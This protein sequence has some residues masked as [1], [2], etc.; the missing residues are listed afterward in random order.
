MKILIISPYIPW[1]LYSGACVRIYNLIKQFSAK[2]HEVILLAGKKD[3]SEDLNHELSNFCKKIYTYKTPT[4]NRIFFIISSIFSFKIYPAIR[5]QSKQFSEALNNILSENKIDVAWV[6]FS[7]IADM[8]PTDLNKSMPVILDQHESEREMYY[9]YLKD[10]NLLEKIFSIINIIKLKKFEKQV[11]SKINALVC[12]SEKEATVAKK[13]VKNKVKIIV[14]SNG[15]DE[16][17]FSKKYELPNIGGKIV[18]CANMAVCRNIEA[19]VW[20][21]TYIFPKVKQQILNAEFQIVGSWP[22]KKVLKLGLVSGVKV[23]G[24]VKDIREY[25][26][27]GNVFVAPYHFGAGTKLKILEAM[28]IKVPVISTDVG[29]QGINVTNNKNIIIANSKYEF[30]DG[31]GHS[32]LP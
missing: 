4:T 14:A 18:F 17:F 10:G 9:G 20:F 16:S 8:L 27:K 25:Y 3:L 19:A 23:I 32:S 6:N 24:M 7:I 31:L 11:F 29:A 5:F 1:P 22:S 13:Y 15:V 2:G 28:A 30:S 12:V 21:T 26:A